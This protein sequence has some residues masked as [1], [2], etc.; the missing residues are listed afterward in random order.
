MIA[1][2]IWGNVRMVGLGFKRKRGFASWE[3][4]GSVETGIGSGCSGKKLLLL[5]R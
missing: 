1:R 4:D 3:E 2:E 5:G